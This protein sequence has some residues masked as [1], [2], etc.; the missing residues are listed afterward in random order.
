MVCKRRQIGKSVVGG[1][2]KSS[3][4]LGPPLLMKHPSPRIKSDFIIYL[5][6]C[7]GICTGSI[8]G[9]V[10]GKE[11]SDLLRLHPHKTTAFGLGLEKVWK[12]G[13][14]VNAGGRK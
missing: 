6:I 14:D 5:L 3:M 9:G 1:E 8:H 7:Q 4:I 11:R 12:N 2:G 10:K 13:T